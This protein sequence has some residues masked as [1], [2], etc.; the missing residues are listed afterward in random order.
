MARR[1]FERAEEVQRGQTLR[2]AALARALRG[3]TGVGGASA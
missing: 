2:Q 3:G 1:A